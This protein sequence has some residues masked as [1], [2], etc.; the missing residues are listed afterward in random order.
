M[1]PVLSAF[2]AALQYIQAFDDTVDHPKR[3]SPLSTAVSRGLPF[4]KSFPA[5]NDA[6]TPRND[7]AIRSLRGLNR[8]KPNIYLINQMLIINFR[9]YRHFPKSTK[10]T[11]R[12]VKVSTAM[13]KSKSCMSCRNRSFTRAGHVHQRRTNTLAHFHSTR[14]PA[15]HR[16]LRR[17]AA[18]PCRRCP[19]LPRQTLP[20]Q[21]RLGLPD[22]HGSSD[23]PLPGVHLRLEDGGQPAARMDETG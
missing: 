11:V 18:D 20:P 1:A 7:P 12:L 3:F 19:C 4:I 5:G 10:P 22:L 2:N 6:C 8:I 17:L 9:D 23:R 21:Y 16:L 13:I 14:V 15:L